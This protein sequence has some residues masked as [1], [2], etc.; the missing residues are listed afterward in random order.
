M[1]QLYISPNL[2]TDLVNVCTGI[3][4]VSSQNRQLSSAI[5]KMM[6]EAS[7]SDDVYRLPILLDLWTQYL[8]YDCCRFLAFSRS[9]NK[10]I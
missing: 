7:L 6:I 1:V 2:R 5:E 10:Y 3:W 8:R 4:L 9:F